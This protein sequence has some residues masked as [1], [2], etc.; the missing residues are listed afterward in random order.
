MMKVFNKRI[1][2]NTAVAL[3]VSDVNFIVLFKNFGCKAV[4]LINN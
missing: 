3:D 2:N 1:L 4:F